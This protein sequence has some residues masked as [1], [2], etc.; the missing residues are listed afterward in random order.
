MC[1]Y[2]YSF[3]SIVILILGHI[4]TNISTNHISKLIDIYLYILGAIKS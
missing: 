3:L 1:L 2:D 4:N